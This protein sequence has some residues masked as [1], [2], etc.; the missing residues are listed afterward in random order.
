MQTQIE[1]I[2]TEAMYIVPDDHKAGAL[3]LVIRELRLLRKEMEVL[4]SAVSEI[5]RRGK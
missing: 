2:R 4:A 3:L 5:N 1:K